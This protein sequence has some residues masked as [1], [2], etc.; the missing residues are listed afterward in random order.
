MIRLLVQYIFSAAARDKIL[1]S[2]LLLIG[3]GVS[4]SL[5]LGSAAVTEKD[6]FSIVFAASALR[7]SSLFTLV[8]F[9]IFYVRKSFDTRDVEYMLSRPVSRLQYLMA[10]AISFSILAFILTSLSVLT[11][12]FMPEEPNLSGLLIW[13]LSLFVE[14]VLMVNVALFFSFVLTSAVSAMLITLAFYVLARMMGGILGVIATTPEAGAMLVMEKMMFL[15]SMIIPR[16][17]LMGQ[18]SW[19]LYGTEG[20][21]GWGFILAQ[22]AVFLGL[23]FSATL[24]DFRR[25]Q[26]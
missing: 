1:L 21:I 25:K 3:V 26:F 6:Q 5:F 11:L 7:L 18:G 9:T 8:F 19:L 20:A 23:I 10:H 13:S 14:L 16:L 12:F 2:F 4:L 24:I 17:D 15:I 22:G